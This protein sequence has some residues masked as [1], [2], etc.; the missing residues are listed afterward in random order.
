MKMAAQVT[1]SSTANQLLTKTKRNKKKNCTKSTKI[2][3]KTRKRKSKPN[4]LP[5]PIKLMRVQESDHQELLNTLKLQDTWISSLRTHT[6]SIALIAQ[7]MIALTLSLTGE[8]SCVLTVPASMLQ[9]TDGERP[10]QK[11]SRMST[12]T[13]SK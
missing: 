13:I 3:K 7:R 10:I 12:G 8:F 5:L 9:T 2:T 1:T 6:T 11:I 4:K